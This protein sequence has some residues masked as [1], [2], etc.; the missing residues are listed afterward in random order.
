MPLADPDYFPGLG[1]SVTFVSPGG[2]RGHRR[3]PGLLRRERACSRLI[4]DEAVTVELPEKLSEAVCRTSNAGLAAHVRRAEVRD[5][6]RVQAVRAGQPLPH[7]VG[8]DARAAGVL[9]GPGERALGDAVGQARPG[10]MEGV[11]RPV[12]L[13]YLE[14]GGGESRRS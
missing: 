7:D 12:P 11:D 10:F 8:P 6:G 13:L 1:N 9:D 3:P 14:N 5:D 2:H 4:W